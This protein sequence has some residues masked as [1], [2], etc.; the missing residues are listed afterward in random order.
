MAKYKHIEDGLQG[1]RE[2]KAA[3]GRQLAELQAL[4]ERSER[5]VKAEEP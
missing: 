1:M 5:R 3:I 2:T 4:I